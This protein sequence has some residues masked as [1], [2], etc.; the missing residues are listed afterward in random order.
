MA[1][2]KAIKYGMKGDEVSNLQTTLNNLGYNLDVDGNFGPKTQAAVKDYQA[3]NNLTVDGMVGPQTTAALTSAS[4]NKSSGTAT[5]ASK[6]TAKDT[7]ASQSA[8]AS[9]PKADTGTTPAASEKV[10]GTPNVLDTPTTVAM[11][12]KFTY[13]DFSYGDYQSSGAVDKAI[14][15]GF[16]YGDFSYADY[17]ESETVKQANAALEAALAAQPGAYQSRWQSQIDDIIGRIMNREKFSY[18]VNEDALYQQ[19]AEQYQHFGK[20]AMQDT[21]GQAAAMTGGYG[22][23]YASTAGNQA[24]QAYLSQLNDVIPELYGM[25]LDRYNAEGQEMYNQYGL[26]SD[27]EAQDYGRYQDS[28]NQWLAERDYAAGRYDSERNLD[29]SKYTDNRNFAYGQYADDKSYA[30]NDYRNAIED[31]KWQETDAYNKYLNDRNFAYGQYS[32]DRSQAYNEYLAAVQQAQWGAS[33]DETVKQNA[34]GNDQWAQSFAETQKQNAIGNDQWQQSFAETQNQNAIGNEQWATSR[35]DA[36]DSENRAYA[37]EEALAVIANGGTP[38]EQQ[39]EAAGLTKEA[40]AAMTVVSSGDV[41]AAL[42]HVSSMSSAEIV[43]TMQAYSSDGD[44]M[45]LAAFLDDCVASGR[46]T[47]AQADSYYEK[48]RK[49]N[50]HTITDTTVPKSS[51]GVSSSK[52]SNSKSQNYIN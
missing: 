24:Y 11:P 42:E 7:A 37:R 31:A 38:S 47:E 14:G 28:Y 41:E 26:L 43:E 25:A 2:V 6:P 48:Y 1:T 21:M 49:E 36:I 8:Q 45:G 22:S 3:K 51:G 18:D 34:I 30:Y 39:L 27:Q 40:A 46:L 10:A 35:Q 23:S 33:F 19:Y 20:L 44:N 29:Y 17:A 15:S 52:G 16:S 50:G 12:E 4:S 5:A 9:T 32:D 13:G